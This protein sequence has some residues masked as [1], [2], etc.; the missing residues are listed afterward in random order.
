MKIKKSLRK[1]WKNIIFNALFAI[2]TLVIVILFYKNILLTVVILI[3]ITAIGLSKW[4]S[5]LTLILFIFGGI[6][7]ALAEMISISSGAWVYTFTNFINIPSWLFIV[8]GNA[9][10][11][12][13]QTALE[14]KKL[15]VKK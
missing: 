6:F 9:T 14:I 8:W 13:Y 15:G 4:K 1:E 2:L 10:A 7:G 11:F 5:I 12:I 3:I